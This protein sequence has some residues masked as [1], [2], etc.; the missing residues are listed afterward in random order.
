MTIQTVW[1][2]LQAFAGESPLPDDITVLTLVPRPCD[3][4]FEVF[5]PMEAQSLQTEE[6]LQD[7]S[8]LVMTATEHG[9]LFIDVSGVASWQESKR[10]WELCE[11]VE[12]KA[13][14][15]VIL[16]FSHCRH[17]DS[18]F[19]G[20]LQ[21]LAS[22]FRA[23]HEVR[24]DIQG[25][26]S[27]LLNEINELGLSE[28]LTHFRPESTPLPTSMRPLH[29]QGFDRADM[30]RLMLRAH[31]SLANADPRNAERFAAVLDVLRNQT[32]GIRT[33]QRT[34]Q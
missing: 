17:L 3:P 12:K 7:G 1:D 4:P 18:T 34:V 33:A 16:D 26:S 23:N 24:F 20:M 28:V 11:E 21:E 32:R 9:R 15:R 25:L 2:S 14:H 27:D 10:I 31:Q 6:A 22:Q 29:A 19:L 5:K 13:I 30:G 8:P